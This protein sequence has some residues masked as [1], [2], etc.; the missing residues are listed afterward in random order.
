MTPQHLTK[1]KKTEQ[2]SLWTCCQ[3][4]EAPW[5]FS[6]DSQS[7]VVWRYFTLPWKLLLSF[8][9]SQK[10][11]FNWLIFSYVY[12]LLHSSCTLSHFCTFVSFH[13]Y[14]Y[15]Y[16]LY[17]YNWQNIKI[18]FCI[19]D[20]SRGFILLPCESDITKFTQKSSFLGTKLVQEK[21]PFTEN[22]NSLVD[23]RLT[24]AN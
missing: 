6:L 15:V 18:I 11:T 23:I 24:S 16:V 9:T 12:Y 5:D 17:L 10:M 1:L 2:Q 7:S 3:Q 20:F 22:M 21:L 4:L 19:F 13:I 14:L 8:L